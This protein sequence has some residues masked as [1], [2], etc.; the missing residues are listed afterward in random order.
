MTRLSHILATRAIP[1]ILT[2]C[3]RDPPLQP[4]E[5]TPGM[6]ARGNSHREAPPPAYSTR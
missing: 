5:I 6:N 3:L 2:E 1:F 4:S